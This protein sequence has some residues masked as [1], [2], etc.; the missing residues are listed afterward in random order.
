M[1]RRKASKTKKI[2][3]QA[4]NS[5]EFLEDDVDDD[6]E[7]EYEDTREE[8]DAIDEDSEPED[9]GNISAI[10]AKFGTSNVGATALKKKMKERDDKRKRAFD[11][12]AEKKI[13]MAKETPVKPPVPVKPAS[14]PDNDNNTSAIE[15]ELE[16]DEVALLKKKKKRIVS[17]D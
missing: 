2:N 3:S 6:E 7:I 10:K 5:T 11:E 9:E 17:D 12:E 15:P 8:L 14:K 16:D 1:N 13:L 4:G